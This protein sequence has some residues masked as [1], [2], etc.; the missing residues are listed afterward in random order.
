MVNKEDD[1]TEELEDITDEDTDIAAEEPELEDLEA[2]EGNKLK[3]LRDKLKDAEEAK[4]QALEELAVAKADF[5]NARKRLE[6][7]RIRDR[8][9]AR[10]EHVYE[11]LPLADSFEMAMS[12]KAVWEKAD[13][14]W[15]KG[16]EG[17]SNQLKKLLADYGVT[18]ID[19]TGETFDPQHHEAVGTEPVTDETLVDTVVSTLQRGYRIDHAGKAEMIRPARVTTGVIE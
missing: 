17:I 6:E 7:D 2:A 19:P 14:R 10:M 5:L 4:R 1:F 11:L 3:Q 16:V 18:A 15:R 8:E 9:R 13:E 12:D